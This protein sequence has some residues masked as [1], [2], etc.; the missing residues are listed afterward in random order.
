MHILAK[1]CSFQENN[2]FYNYSSVKKGQAGNIG[3]Q[4]ILWQII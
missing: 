3:K 1:R 4:K 2:S